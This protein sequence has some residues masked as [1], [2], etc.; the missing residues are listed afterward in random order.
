M[1]KRGDAIPE[2][3]EFGT[4]QRFFQDGITKFAFIRPHGGGA[5]VHCGYQVLDRS[6][7]AT[8]DAGT[9]VAYR[10][11]RMPK[12]LTV[13]E[14]FCIGQSDVDRLRNAI[15]KATPPAEAPVAVEPELEAVA[16]ETAPLVPADPPDS[17]KLDP[18]LWMEVTIRKVRPNRSA[19][20]DHET[21]GQIEIPWQ[22]LERTDIRSARN[23]DRFEVRCKQ[24]EKDLPQ[25]IQIRRY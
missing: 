7:I 14:F 9:M 10:S 24:G 25:A 17:K 16:A 22:V 20:A 6:S 23:S 12:G 2:N 15:T 18:D 13:D 1:W 5:K 3:V 21:I 4:V 11:R 8:L 19:F